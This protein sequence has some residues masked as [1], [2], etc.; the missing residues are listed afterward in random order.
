M[1]T[2]DI[3][4]ST[5]KSDL[6]ALSKELELSDLDNLVGWLAEKDKIKKYIS[7]ALLGGILDAKSKKLVQAQLLT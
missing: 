4:L 1:I 5:E 7:D 3:L 2:A 6:S